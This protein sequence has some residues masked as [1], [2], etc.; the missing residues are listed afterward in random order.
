MYLTYTIITEN[1]PSP[2]LFCEKRYEEKKPKG[3]FTNI[4]LKK[5]NRT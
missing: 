4:M 3:L 2:L 5:K 1:M